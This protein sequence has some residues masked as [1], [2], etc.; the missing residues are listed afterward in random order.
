MNAIFCEIILNLFVKWVYRKHFRLDILLF[1]F[2]L[3][4]KDQ[5]E[6]ETREIIEKD[7]GNTVSARPRRMSEVKEEAEPI[8]PIPE[9]SSYFILSQTNRCDIYIDFKN[10]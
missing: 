7:G 9:G 2:A 5:E 3:K 10:Q 6:E 8:L 1:Y 4:N